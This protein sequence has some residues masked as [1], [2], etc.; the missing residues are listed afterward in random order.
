MHG[1]QRFQIHKSDRLELLPTAH[2]CFNQVLMFLWIVLVDVSGIDGFVVGSACLWLIWNVEVYAFDCHKVTHLFSFCVGFLLS[3]CAEVF[4][5]NYVSSLRIFV[6]CF[7]TI[8]RRE[9]SSGFGFIWCM[10]KS[11]VARL[12]YVRSNWIVWIAK[13]KS[14]C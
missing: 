14:R 13:R 10:Y 11:R 12:P 1:P 5:S 3:L 8:L 7:L 9:G 2:T 4:A 6:R